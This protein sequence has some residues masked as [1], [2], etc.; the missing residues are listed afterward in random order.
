MRL[1]GINNIKPNEKLSMTVFNQDGAV[2]LPANTV[3]TGSYIERLKNIGINML[4]IQDDYFEDVVVKP[5]LSD[6]TK[7][8]VLEAINNAYAAIAKNKPINSIAIM[9]SVDN[10]V[11]EIGL[12]LK[13]PLNIINM[14][15]IKDARCHHAVNVAT[16]V[17]AIATNYYYDQENSGTVIKELIT[18]ALLHD[19]FLN[20]MKD[21]AK[22]YDHCEKV[23]KFLK[24]VP[25]ISTKT[26]ISCYQHH[27]RFD[28]SGHPSR[29]MLDKIFVGA[30]M[31]AVADT[32]DNL[33]NG[34]AGQKPMREHEAYEYVNAV[35]GSVLDPVMVKHFNNS[36]AIYPSGA[37][38][39]LS[40][41]YNAVVTSQTS[42]PSR[43]VVRLSM[44]KREDCLLFDLTRDKTLFIE[45]VIY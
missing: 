18:A 12:N 16:I 44:P 19:L 20:D 40:N 36:V 13:E 23:Y 43:P 29:L 5:S 17:A 37:T 9:K 39:L 25:N 7:R 42:M 10:I 22:D 28:G 34:F 11:D 3:I 4:Y 45:Q 8:S 24:S 35:S 6:D 21:D 2:L 1:I 31:I 30:R 33:V 14:F 38:V 15:A 27:E 26:Y 41:G 32:Y